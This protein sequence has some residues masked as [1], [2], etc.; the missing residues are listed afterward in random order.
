MS[1]PP[2]SAA[3][4]GIS[5]PQGRASL[6]AGPLAVGGSLALA[7][8]AVVASEPGRSLWLPPC[9]LLALTGIA[10]PFCG[11]T[12]AVHAIGQGDLGAA[13]GFNPLVVVGIPV[14]LLLFV[15]WTVR[16]ARGRA[17]PL[18]DP[19]SRQLAILGSVL[20]AFA[21]LRN[22]PGLELLHP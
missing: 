20:L 19:S 8:A 12:R 6:L 17:V 7:T 10:C 16:R 3:V 5:Q 2:T 11:G 18:A 13:L 14:F 22:L 21:V 4:P 15:R 9:P 1:T